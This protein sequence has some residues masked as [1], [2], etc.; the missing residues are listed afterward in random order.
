MSCSGFSDCFP[1][2]NF[3]A[4]CLFWRH[5]AMCS[6][7]NSTFYSPVYVNAIEFPIFNLQNHPTLSLVPFHLILQ[8]LHVQFEVSHH[9][10]S[11]NHVC[12]HTPLHY[13]PYPALTESP[14]W[15][16]QPCDLNS[17]SDNSLVGYHSLFPS[18]LDAQIC[19]FISYHF[20]STELCKAGAQTS[21]ISLGLS[22]Y[23]H[24]EPAYAVPCRRDMYLDT[25]VWT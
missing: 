4:Q 7:G 3:E 13:D 12:F 2:K 8:F 18:C 5:L 1:G 21:V 16:I 14:L 15:E 9:V 11:C 6:W 23:F 25:D 22:L 10:L 20:L 19:R 17:T 24:N